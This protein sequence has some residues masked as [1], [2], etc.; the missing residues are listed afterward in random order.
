MLGRPADD[1]I[2]G[3][4]GIRRDLAATIVAAAERDRSDT[5]LSRIR[6]AEA[7]NA[8][9]LDAALAE[10]AAILAEGGVAEPAALRLAVAGAAQRAAIERE[11]TAA[12]HTLVALSGPGEAVTAFKADLAG[13]GDLA[14]IQ[15]DLEVEVEQDRALEARRASLLEGLGAE[16]ETIARIERSAESAELRQQRAD[17]IAELRELAETWSV[18]SIALALLRRTRE[19]YEREHRPD[20]LKAAEELLSAW[21][22]GRYVRILAPLGKQVQELERNDG[23]IVPLGG[24]S[25]GTAQQLYLALRFGL[26]DHFARQAESLPVVMD[27]ILVNFDPERAERAARSIE[28][29]ATR[30]QVLYFTCHPG[31]LLNATREIDLP[32]V[33]RA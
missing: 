23:V 19:R 15:A 16:R 22:G 29:L 5:E 13:I 28:D 3:L 24:L 9:A 20:V 21:T 12:D 4:D 6:A 10:H 11:V 17:R 31:T 32:A 8:V 25:T 33:G 18:T 27:D 7:S 2:S 30:H 1:P 26:V 14:R